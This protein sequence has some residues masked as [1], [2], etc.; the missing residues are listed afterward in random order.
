MRIVLSAGFVMVLLSLYFVF[1]QVDAFAN[2]Q[3]LQ[4]ESTIS[5][6]SLDGMN[7]ENRVVLLDE[8]SEKS[9]IVSKD[10]VV[11]FMLIVLLGITAFILQYSWGTIRTE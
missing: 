10:H 5:T 6:A 1:E 9:E 7:S 8:Q 4:T 11:I 2:E 3:E